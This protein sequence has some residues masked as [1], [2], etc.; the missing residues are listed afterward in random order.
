MS[1]QACRTEMRKIRVEEDWVVF[2][3][4]DCFYLDSDR[5]RESWFFVSFQDVGPSTSDA[6]R[7]T[8][9]VVS[10]ERMSTPRFSEALSILKWLW[11][12]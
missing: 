2:Q 5:P 4:K 10:T 8:F 1:G 9:L 11:L 7:V 3:W 6:T 12:E